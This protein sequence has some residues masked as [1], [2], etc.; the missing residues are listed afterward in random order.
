[1]NNLGCC[2]LENG[3]NFDL[4]TVTDCCIM[5][6]DGRGL[7]VLIKDYNG[8]PID[9][10]KIF[11]IK[12]KR[13]EAQKEKTIYDCEGC[14]HLNDYK[15]TGEKKISEFHFSQCRICNA[16]CIYCSHEYSTLT[17]NYDTYPIIKDLIDKGFYKSGGEATLQGGEPT[18][19]PHFDEL[20]ALFTEH[21]TKI[22]VHSSAIRYSNTV[23]NALKNAKARG[24]DLRC[25]ADSNS[26]GE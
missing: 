11:E 8:E 17:L 5:H 26:K 19:M 10:N 23:E 22:R 6:N 16:K 25:V 7:P 4:N 3:I 13:I 21:G 24:V 15:F 14:Y 9:W 1:M 2:F 18:L 12:A 20:V